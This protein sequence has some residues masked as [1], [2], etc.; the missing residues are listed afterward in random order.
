MKQF[1]VNF[2]KFFNLIPCG[3]IGLLFI[4]IGMSGNIILLLFIY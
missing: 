2:V 1:G 4:A 3:I